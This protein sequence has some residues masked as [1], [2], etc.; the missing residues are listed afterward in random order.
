MGRR[1]TSV[2]RDLQRQARQAGRHDL[3]VEFSRFAF[4]SY[5]PIA[6]RGLSDLIGRL[7]KEAPR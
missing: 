2:V 1:L 4:D 7:I 3:A 6:D 5:D